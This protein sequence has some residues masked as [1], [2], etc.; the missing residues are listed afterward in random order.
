[1]QLFIWV[2]RDESYSTRLSFV[3]YVEGPLERS[4]GERR[5]PGNR[6]RSGVHTHLVVVMTEIYS[7]W[8]GKAVSVLI[9]IKNLFI[10]I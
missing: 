10:Y 6:C 3:G 9:F 1:M 8:G 7:G 2:V 4:G 5:T